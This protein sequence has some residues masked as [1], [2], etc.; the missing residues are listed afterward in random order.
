VEA[1][2]D[3]YLFLLTVILISLS[4]VMTPGPLF[5]VTIIRS[6]KK[7]TTGILI[8]L[9]HGVIEFPLIFLIYVGFAPF[10]TSSLTQKLVALIGGL[11]MIFMGFRMIRTG[12]KGG[13]EHEEAQH[14][15]LIA[16]ILMTGANPYFLLWWAT[17]GTMLI[18]NAATFGLL[19]LAVFSI[20]H[21]LC[22]LLWNTFVSLIVFK[23]RQFWTKKVQKII[24]GF[25]F[26]IL[27]GFGTWFIV[28][29]LL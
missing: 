6:F 12:I 9:G 3:F 29:A 28:S 5:A 8:S 17:V 2:A 13:G 4:G 21:W 26:I 22:D 1:I 16:G 23:S 18:L 7:K 15:S 14:S 10:F 19:G 27:I 25:C 24:F 20:V 11:L